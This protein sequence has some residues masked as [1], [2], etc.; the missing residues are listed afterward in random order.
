[1]N[2]QKKYQI[3]FR[4]NGKVIEL[5]GGQN[6]MIHPNVDVVPGTNVDIVAD[7]EKRL[8]FEDK[9]VDGVF[10][11]YAIEHISWKNVEHFIQEVSRILTDN[12]KAIFFTS[13]LLEQCKSLINEGVNKA[14]V[15][16]LFGSQEF[17]NH[18]GAHKCGFSPEYAE[19]LFKENGF[20]FV[21]VIEHPISKTDMI[22]E[23]YKFKDGEVFE[24]SY[25]EDGIFGYDGYR[26]FATHYTTANILLNSTPKIE[27][28]LDIGG[29]R[30]YVARILE[31]NGIKAT[32]MDI[33][34]HCRD[35][36][37]IEHFILHDA[38]QI[39]WPGCEGCK[40]PIPDKAF[41]L[42]FSINFLEHIPTEKL[43]DV[44][45]EMARVSKRGMHGIHFSESPFVEQDPDIDITHTTN[46]TKEWWEQKFKEVV[47]EYQVVLEHPR[48]LEY[49]EPEKQP[50]LS[51]CPT[52]DDGLLKVNLGSFTDMFYFDWLNLDIVDLQDFAK[53]QS[54]KFQQHDV[55][56]GLP[57]KDETVDFIFSSHL[58]EHLD[59]EQGMK[60]LKECYRVMKKGAIMRLIFPDGKKIS[61]DYVDGTMGKYR[62]VNVGVENAIDNADAFYNLLM[63]GHKTVYDEGI[64]RTLQHIGF[65]EIRVESPFKSRSQVIQTQTLTNHH[66]LSLVL[67]MEK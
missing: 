57:W 33:S 18:A 16:R 22:I 62:Y 40:E 36:R 61:R 34:K 15:E 60:F 39:P 26:D 58:I 35:T 47:P 20:D 51:Y 64:I 37:V 49:E 7:F 4:P 53:S 12:G 52:I 54:Y 65:K 13:N 42:T 27:S 55:T 31:N 50:P 25:F 46:E 66:T 38:T 67:E 6:P 21:K 29:C 28:V 2:E 19:K 45:R 24:R 63:A 11:K 5:G 30:G 48:L 44:L 9:T 1:M 43:D 56:E 59:R 3:R 10:C 14:T 23:A 17:P 8:P 41:D 32:T